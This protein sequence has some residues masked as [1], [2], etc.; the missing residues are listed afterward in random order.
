M[1]DFLA[2]RLSPRS[3]RL[4]FKVKLEKSFELSLRNGFEFKPSIVCQHSYRQIY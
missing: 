1:S 2:F 3:V 4:R